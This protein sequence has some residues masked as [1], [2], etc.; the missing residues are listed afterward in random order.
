MALPSF[1]PVGRDLHQ[2]VEHELRILRV[3]GLDVAVLVRLHQAEPGVW[4][5]SL[6]FRVA[7]TGEERRTADILR[8]AGESQVWDSVR[9]LGAHHLRDLFRS[10]T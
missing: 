1:Q 6:V 7:G 5:G 4:V 3:D 9:G 8:G 10:L 2:P